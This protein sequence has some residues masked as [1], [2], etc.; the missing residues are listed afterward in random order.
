M[1]R[2]ADSTPPRLSVAT[3]TPFPEHQTLSSVEVSLYADTI[4]ARA[5]SPLRTGSSDAKGHLALEPLPAGRY[6]LR[7]R[8]PGTQ[9]FFSIVR[10]RAAPSDSLEVRLVTDSQICY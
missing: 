9:P 3:L 6:G 1:L 2:L 7:A 4:D 10:L 8:R 5:T